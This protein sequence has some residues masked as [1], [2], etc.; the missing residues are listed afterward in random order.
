MAENTS[1]LFRKR[2]I[3]DLANQFE[4]ATDSHR[5]RASTIPFASDVSRD[6]RAK[7]RRSSRRVGGNPSRSEGMGGYPE[8]DRSGKRGDQGHIKAD[9]G[10]WS[11]DRKDET[12]LDLQ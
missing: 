3:D 10:I 6:A 12:H 4:F 9:N 11:K 8:R 7:V 2:I 5:T 1:A